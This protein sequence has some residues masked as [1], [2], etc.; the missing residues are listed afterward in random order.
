MFC[1]ESN[2]AAAVDLLLVKQGRNESKT[3]P[4]RE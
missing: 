3:S 4:P 1:F 2:A